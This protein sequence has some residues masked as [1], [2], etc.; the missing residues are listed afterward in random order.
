MAGL[1][2]FFRFNRRMLVSN[3]WREERPTRWA[4]VAQFFHLIASVTL[5]SG[6][7]ARANHLFWTGA[8]L[9]VGV[10]VIGTIMTFLEEAQ[11]RR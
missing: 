9:M 1:Q 10:Q 11:K 7:G 8:V 4:I 2:A 6:L 3:V 5:L